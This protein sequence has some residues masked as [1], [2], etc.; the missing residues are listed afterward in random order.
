MMSSL[1]EKLAQD[2]FYFKLVKTIKQKI[3]WKAGN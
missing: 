3:L 2:W 1:F